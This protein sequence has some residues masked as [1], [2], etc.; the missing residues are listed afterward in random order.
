MKSPIT[1]IEERELLRYFIEQYKK[2]Y[3]AILK[4]GAVD[5]SYSKHDSTLARCALRITAEGFSPL[6]DKGKR[7]LANLRRFV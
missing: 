2:T 3:A 1:K 7:E 4:S 6:A 5:D